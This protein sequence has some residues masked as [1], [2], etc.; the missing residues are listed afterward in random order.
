MVLLWMF[1]VVVLSGAHIAPRLAAIMDPSL[2]TY[3]QTTVETWTPWQ[4]EH[5][6]LPMASS[7]L[8]NRLVWGVAPVLLLSFMLCN[9]RREALLLE[10]LPRGRSFSRKAV[11]TTTPSLPLYPVSCAGTGWGRLLWQ[12][13]IW[14]FSHIVRARGFCTGALIV[15]AMGLFSGFV[16]GVWHAEGPM[17]PRPEFI[18]PLLNTTL[19]LIIAF[20][21]AAMVGMVW[22]RDSVEG[23]DAMLDATPAPVWFRPFGRMLALVGVICGLTM[24]PG[25]AGT[26]ITAFIAPASFSVVTPFL[27]QC[28][29]TAPPLL[30][31]GLLALVLHACISRASIAYALS[32]LLTF[33]LVLNHELGLVNYPPLEVGI[34][35][36]LSLSGQTGWRPWLGYLLALDGYKLALCGVMAALAAAFAARGAGSRVQGLRS[37]IRGPVTLVSG[38]AFVA[39]AG[40][41]W[42]LHSKLVAAGDYIESGAADHENALWEKHWLKT[43]GYY[44]V[45]GG[46]VTLDVQTASGRLSGDWTLQG[47]RASEGMLHAELPKAFILSSAEVDGKPANANIA[48]DHMV[49]PLGDTTTAH[50]VRLRWTL[51][52][53]GWSSEGVPPWHGYGAL[54]LSSFTAMPRLGLDPSRLLRAPT[55]RKTYGFKA[56]P[57]L[58]G[59]MASVAADAVAPS[60]QWQWAVTHD[61]TPLATSGQPQTAPLSF[62]VGWAPFA[63]TT[64]AGGLQVLYDGTREEDAKTIIE[65][66]LAM[67]RC[68][69][70]RLGLPVLLTTIVQWPRGLEVQ[71][72][73]AETLVLPEA[74]Y[75]DVAVQGTGRAL[76]R[77]YIATVLARQALVNAASL[78]VAEG[79]GWWQAAVPG[80]IGLLCLGD[81]D[82]ESALQQVLAL[83]ADHVAQALASVTAPVGD[84]AQADT[85]GWVSVYGP[86]AAL[87][88]TVR[89]LPEDFAAINQHIADGM[90]VEQAVGRHMSNPERQAAFGPPQAVDFVVGQNKKPVAQLFSW[91][92][93]EWVKQP[94]VPEML[95]LQHRGGALVAAPARADVAPKGL[96]VAAA[97]AYQRTHPSPHLT[98]Q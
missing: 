78:R 20:I 9:V 64:R 22:R 46:R 15:L 10:P 31:L 54:W 35:A 28:L 51:P 89:Q 69:V 24:L 12:E 90:S 49:L 6:L 33:F 74:P 61:G 66:A 27:Y 83:E 80:A 71:G 96:F 5:A 48:L 88:W 70:R 68:V 63:R 30:E 19:F 4:K 56:A 91:Q 65:D 44:Q 26:T 11:Y 41:G 87:G 77:A 25:L 95:R 32:M 8:I 59:S 97:P 94:Q 1:A 81:V 82:G 92:A 50:D 93:G 75:W 62:A 58:P 36:H 29:V 34:P 18:L 47:V 14:Q 39:V 45:S 72:G 79:S 38:T 86:L 53:P 76:R 60:G 73:V 55:I 13:V 16:H 7:F 2:F 84:L 52:P 37:R 85:A 21:V 40:L 98:K 57:I 43:A 3:A 23:L 17:V 42:L 67:R